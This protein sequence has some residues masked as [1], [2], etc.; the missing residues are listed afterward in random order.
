MIISAHAH[1]GDT[2]VFDAESSEEALLQ[3]MDNA[4][5]DVGDR[6]LR[7]LCVVQ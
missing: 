4:G 3:S 6:D 7:V 2:R 5:V 1:I